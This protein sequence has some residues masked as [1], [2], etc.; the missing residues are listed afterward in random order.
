MRSCARCRPLA[1]G[2]NSATACIKTLAATRSQ[3][4]RRDDAREPHKEQTTVGLPA[5]KFRLTEW[6]L[7]WFGIPFAKRRPRG[8]LWPRSASGAMAS[9]WMIRQESL[10]QLIADLPAGGGAGG[11]CPRP[12]ENSSKRRGDVIISQITPRLR[13]NNLKGTSYQHRHYLL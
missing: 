2:S 7:S 1:F 11:P 5:Q 10:D 13:N 4:T 6:A 12:C 9:I 3:R 8:A